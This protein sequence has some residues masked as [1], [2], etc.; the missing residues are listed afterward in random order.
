[1]ELRISKDQCEMKNME[2]NVDALNSALMPQLSD[3]AELLMTAYPTVDKP[4]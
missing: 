4:Y 3:S 2:I 1:M